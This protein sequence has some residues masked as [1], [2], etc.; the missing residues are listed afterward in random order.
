MGGFGEL[1]AE[2]MRRMWDRQAGATV[3][4]MLDELPSDRETAYTTVMT[5]M[6]KLLKRGW[7]H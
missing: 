7:L 1:K 3:R 2:L 6:D 4:E 5:V